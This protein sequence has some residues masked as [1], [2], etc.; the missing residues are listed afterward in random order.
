MNTN[1][2]LPTPSFGHTVKVAIVLILTLVFTACTT[3]LKSKVAGNLN[4][5]SEQQQSVA[6]LP[7]EII[8]KDQKETA[9]RNLISILSNAMLWMVF[10]KNMA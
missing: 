10:L 7:V 6:I 8:K 9:K 1:F 5:V 2:F 3:S 4:H